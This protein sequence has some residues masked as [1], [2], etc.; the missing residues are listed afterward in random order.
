MSKLCTS[1]PSIALDDSRFR[2][3]G[4]IK[5]MALDQL[6]ESCEIYA[7]CYDTYI[8][9]TQKMARFYTDAVQVYHLKKEGTPESTPC[10]N[11]L[12]KIV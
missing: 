3:Y 9:H 5:Q 11:I 8:L 10:E 4:K 1:N 7:L 12:L 6:P 2:R